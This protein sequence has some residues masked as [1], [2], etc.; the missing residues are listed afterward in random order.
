MVQLIE[1]DVNGAVKTQKKFANAL[2]KTANGIPIVGHVK[3]AIHYACGYK[4]E[5]KRIMIRATRTTAVMGIGAAG[6]ILG[7]PVLAVVLG[8][9]GG[10]IFDLGATIIGDLVSG[11]HRPSGY[12]AAFEN[13][14]ENPD[15]GA[16][17]DSFLIPV[18]DGLAGYAGG[19]LGASFGA[20]PLQLSPRPISDLE[21]ELDWLY[22]EH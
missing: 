15:P 14:D 11:E 21:F 17:F 12:F 19:T 20:T 10:I 13:I 22:L 8:I 7:G 4:E 1:G 9:G 2:L 18:C 5:G 3:G 16:I 6:F